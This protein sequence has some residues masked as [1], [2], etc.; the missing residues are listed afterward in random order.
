MCA[1][2]RLFPSTPYLFV[3]GKSNSAARTLGF[4]SGGYKVVRA[5]GS[6]LLPFYHFRQLIAHYKR[7]VFGSPAI[8]SQYAAGLEHSGRNVRLCRRDTFVDI[9]IRNKLGYQGA[10]LQLYEWYRC[11]NRYW[12]WLKVKRAASDRPIWTPPTIEHGLVGC[13]V[14]QRVFGQWN[15]QSIKCCWPHT[16]TSPRSLLVK[17]LA[18]EVDRVVS[19]WQKIRKDYGGYA[20]DT[21]AK[22]SDDEG[23]LVSRR[24]RSF[25]HLNG[26]QRYFPGSIV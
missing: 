21:Q 17:H 16:D 4:D 19:R 8:S 2:K 3:N 18:Y 22:V 13:C 15:R 7:H 24:K 11:S 1:T 5:E 12:C 6:V 25:N 9:D 23:W 20:S 26:S 14:V 10:G